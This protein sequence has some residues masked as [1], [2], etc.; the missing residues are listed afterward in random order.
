MTRTTRG[1]L[2]LACAVALLTLTAGEWPAWA[3]TTPTTPPATEEQKTEETGDITS[4]VEMT[5]AA[6]QV[7]RQA[8]VTAA[9][10]FE[11]KESEGFWP[12]YREYR[13]EMAKVNDRFVRLLGG[14]L[15][16]YDTLT[17]EA[18]RK[19]IDE[20]LSI[21]RARLALKQRY[22]SRFSKV[23]PAKKMARFFQIDHKFDTVIM[24]ELAQTV[25][26]A[27]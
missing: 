19:T 15:E 3:Q 23:L 10:D 16:N 27:K 6:I 4:E 20:Y 26:L 24:A 2:T 9:M 13:L 11:P 21:E 22:V 12:L 5:R 1:A 25:P 14:Y 8:L 18:A 7:R 17:N